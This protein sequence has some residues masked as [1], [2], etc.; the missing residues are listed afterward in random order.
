MEKQEG[1]HHQH[2]EV[3]AGRP[4]RRVGP[5][6]GPSLGL[7]TRVRG[8]GLVQVVLARGHAAVADHVGHRD[9]GPDLEGQVQETAE[10]HDP[11]DE[12]QDHQEDPDQDPVPGIWTETVFTWQ[13]LTAM[14]PNEIWRTPSPSLDH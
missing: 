1:L 11:P 8:R 6:Q 13:I 12:D 2:K 9:Q 10:G 14:P 4:L 3:R 5:G 7:Q